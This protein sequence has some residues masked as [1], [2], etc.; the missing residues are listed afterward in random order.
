MPAVDD[1]EEGGDGL[2]GQLAAQCGDG[3]EGVVGV[4]D[5]GVGHRGGS[6]LTKSVAERAGLAVR[7][8]GALSAGEAAAIALIFD[9]TA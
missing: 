7:A 6:G 5:L 1:A 3:V 4:G 9:A 8:E 2:G